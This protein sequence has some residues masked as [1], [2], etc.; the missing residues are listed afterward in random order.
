MARTEWC[1]PERSPVFAGA[2]GQ[3]MLGDA[4][5]SPLRLIRTCRGGAAAEDVTGR[6]APA[7]ARP[8]VGRVLSALTRPWLALG[9]VAVAAAVSMWA[10][11]QVPQARWELALLGLI[12]WIVGKYVL[13]PLRWHAL[14][15]ADR[16]RTWHL[17]VYAE[18]EV[19]G[20]LTPGRVGAELWR[21]HRLERDAALPRSRA[22]VEVALDRL[23]G[24]AGGLV[25]LLLAAVALPPALWLP[26]LLLALGLS[27]VLIALLRWRPALM[28]THSTPPWPVIAKCLVLSVAHQLTVIGLWLGSLAAL[29]AHPH[30]LTVLGA[31]LASQ[32]AAVVPGVNGLLS[33]REGALVLAL[34]SAG[35]GWQTATGAVALNA[36]LS[37][38]AALLL[39]GASHAAR[40][41]AQFQP[42]SHRVRNWGAASPTS[43]A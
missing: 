19:L 20:L 28:T 29:G 24:A 36:V 33:P 6:G 16:G 7:A 41:I 8:V 18:G 11:E 42:A 21:V 43:P 38:A 14:S 2:A 30:P 25:L 40:W 15:D 3:P 9:V 12:P 32:A 17:R 31:L 4:S 13:C 10:L 22:V 37:S 34:A 1:S 26:A 5:P 27:V 23:C 39:G 35:V